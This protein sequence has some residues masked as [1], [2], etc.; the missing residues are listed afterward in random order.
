MK[1][2]STEKHI[3]N[4]ITVQVSFTKTIQ[5]CTCDDAIFGRIGMAG[6]V[7]RLETQFSSKLVNASNGSW[8]L[9]GNEGGGWAALRGESI[10]GGS[11]CCGG[12]R[13]HD[14]STTCDGEVIGACSTLGDEDEEDSAFGDCSCR[15][16]RDKAD[17][18]RV[19]FSGAEK[20]HIEEDL[21]ALK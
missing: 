6:T 10:R 18:A 3:K 12:E 1:H 9:S 17:T 7:C 21:D 19:M 15:G 4:H 13:A 14:L 20:K 2:M 5:T 16:V 8:W 11:C